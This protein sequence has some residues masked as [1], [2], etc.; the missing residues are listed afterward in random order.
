VRERYYRYSTYLKERFGSRVH[1]ISV[2]AGFSCPNRDGTKG[3]DGCI[4]CDNKGFSFHARIPPIP[5]EEQ[6]RTGMLFNKERF[7]ADKFI[8]YFQAYTNTHAPLEILRQRY[9]AIRKFDNIVGIAIGTRPD[10]VSPEIL[11]LI[12]SFSSSYDVWI[13]YG[14]QS[15]HEQSLAFLGR[16]HGVHDFENAV[17]LTRRYKRIKIAAHVILGIPGESKD[18][19]IATAKF[20]AHIGIDGVKLH[21]LHVVRNTRLEALYQEQNVPLLSQED[22]IEYV[23]SFLEHLPPQVVIQRL[24]ADC[25]PDY[26]VAPVWILKKNEILSAIDARMASRN[27]F[28]G[29]SI[30]SH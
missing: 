9:T 16:G 21:P 29:S 23:I 15:I 18:D 7:K 20:L 17:S 24:T 26:L 2:D 10:S 4:F 11:D 22:Y 28:Q 13:E 12:D 5:L 3:S 8:V 27:C 19:S 25:H 14:L 30:S 6:I 1:K